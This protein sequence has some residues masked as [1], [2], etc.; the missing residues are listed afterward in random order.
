[1]EVKQKYGCK[2]CG[3]NWTLI[4]NSDR[5]K[6][7]TP[8]KTGD[9]PAFLPCSGGYIGCRMYPLDGS[10]DLGPQSLYGLITVYFIRRD[11]GMR[12]W[13]DWEP[14]KETVNVTREAFSEILKD[15]AWSIPGGPEIQELVGTKKPRFWGMK[16]NLID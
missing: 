3:S 11:V 4:W 12:L 16:I 13:S 14:R 9:F 1:M 10:K 2:V 5:Y 8:P 15:E 6:N 7:K